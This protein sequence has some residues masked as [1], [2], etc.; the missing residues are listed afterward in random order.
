MC[1]LTHDDA[2]H[3]SL[4]LISNVNYEFTL[5]STFK[6]AVS[7]VCTYAACSEIEYY[8]SKR[9]FLSPW[10]KTNTFHSVPHM[11]KTLLD[12]RKWM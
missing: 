6:P 1:H 9:A 3:T 4:H 8:K 7:L 10:K 12:R 11:K 2:S 5:S